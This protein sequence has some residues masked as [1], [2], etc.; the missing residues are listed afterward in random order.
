MP[1]FNANLSMMFH[2][3]DFFDRFRAAADAGFKGVEFL[4]PYAYSLSDL[5]EALEA[6]QLTQVLFN[7]PLVIGRKGKEE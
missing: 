3:H 4:F 1:H 2:E 7:L 5:K 6:N